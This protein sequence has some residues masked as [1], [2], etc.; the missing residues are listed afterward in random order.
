MTRPTAVPTTP[1]ERV[2]TVGERLKRVSDALMLIQASVTA[3]A[4]TECQHD[5]FPVPGAEV[6]VSAGELFEAL[7][8]AAVEA[9]QEISLIREGA[10]NALTMPAPVT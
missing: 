8:A 4:S 9:H 7:G 5:F 3:L 6:Q 10:P 2:D 1:I